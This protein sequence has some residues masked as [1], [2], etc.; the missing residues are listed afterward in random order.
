MIFAGVRCTLDPLRKMKRFR[1]LLVQ[2]G[3]PAEG[4]ASAG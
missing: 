2:M 1:D 4:R 3:M